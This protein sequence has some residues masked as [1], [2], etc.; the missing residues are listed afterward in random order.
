MITKKE[1]EKIASLARIKMNDDEMETMA[2]ELAAVLEYVDQLKEVNTRGTEPNINP[3]HSLKNVFRNDID[4]SHEPA[5]NT[6]KL[7]EQAQE[8]KDGFVKVKAVFS[9]EK[10]SNNE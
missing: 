7:L 6:T 2:K 1:V 8:V 5:A 3:H 9:N 4:L 10:S